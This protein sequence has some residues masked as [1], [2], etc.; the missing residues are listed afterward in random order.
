MIIV[1]E[2][3]FFKVMMASFCIVFQC[4]GILY[5]ICLILHH[6]PFRQIAM[7]TKRFCEEEP[8]LRLDLK[9]SKFKNPFIVETKKYLFSDIIGLSFVVIVV[10]TDF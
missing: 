3:F 5:K 4:A 9:I 6:S 8:I 10:G 2:R 1:R 7:E